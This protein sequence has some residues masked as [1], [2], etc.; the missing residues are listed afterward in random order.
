MPQY[1]KNHSKIVKLLSYIYFVSV[2]ENGIQMYKVCN[3][4]RNMS[5]LQKLNVCPLFF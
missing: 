5:L 2:Y 1:M 3:E 4:R